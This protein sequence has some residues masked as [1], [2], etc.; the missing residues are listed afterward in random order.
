M[1][2]GSGGLQRLAAYP[3]GPHPNPLPEGEG[4]VTGVLAERTR[5]GVPAAGT[6]GSGRPASR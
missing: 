3:R 4:V 5:T 6:D 2:R 1:Q